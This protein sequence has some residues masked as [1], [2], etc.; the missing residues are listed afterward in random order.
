M[1]RYFF[2]FLRDHL[3]QIIIALSSFLV[4]DLFLVAFKFPKTVIIFIDIFFA[5]V[6][7]V[8]FIIEYAR[9]ANFY[10]QLQENFGQLAQKYLITEILERPNFLDGQILHDLLYDA[11]KSM[12][13]EIINNSAALD[14]FREYLELWIHEAKTPIA[15][16]TL[17]NRNP[18][19]ATELTALDNYL[20]QILYFA[21]SKNANQD[22]LFKT[23]KLSQIIDRLAERNRVTLQKQGITLETSGLDLVVNTDPK[24]LEFMVNQLLQNSIKYGAK[25]IAISA[26][27]HDG[28]VELDLID[29][30][31]GIS[32]KDL[33]RVFEKSFTG[34]NGRKFSG[35]HSTGMGLYIVKNLCDKLGHEISITSPDQSGT[36]VTIIFHVHNYYKNVISA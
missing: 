30:G 31:I 11:N 14:D 29:D 33:P 5:V 26:K 15:T 32:A 21:R 17:L 27:K 18:D 6:F 35:T 23:A 10:R 7:T 3:V 16:M 2:Q 22:Y 24:W 8:I 9:R 36:R 1:K 25:N 34:Q 4:L 28:Q 19:I 13:E 12:R 20:E